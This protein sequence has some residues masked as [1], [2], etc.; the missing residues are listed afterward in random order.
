MLNNLYLVEEYLTYI[1]LILHNIIIMLSV[2]Y[3]LLILVLGS[4]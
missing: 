1:L 2:K 3:S 4:T